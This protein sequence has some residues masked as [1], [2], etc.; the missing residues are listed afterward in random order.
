MAKIKIFKK[1][2]T[3]TPYFWS[4]RDTTDKTNLT[5]YKQTR[6]G[7]KRMRGVHYDA[8]AKRMCKEE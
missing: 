7:V 5:V 8:V 4:D 2:G 1:D 6:D 3:P